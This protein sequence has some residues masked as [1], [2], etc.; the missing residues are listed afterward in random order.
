M[1]RRAASMSATVTLMPHLPPDGTVRSLANTIA[2]TTD[3]APTIAKTV[4]LASG[5]STLHLPVDSK[6]SK[7]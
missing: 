7:A 4:P 6:D 5:P 3:I 2:A 1:V